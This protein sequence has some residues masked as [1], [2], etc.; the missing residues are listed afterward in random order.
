M[1]ALCLCMAFAIA[2]GSVCAGACGR[3]SL[4]SL[5]S[6]AFDIGEISRPSGAC[7]STESKEVGWEVTSNDPVGIASSSGLMGWVV[8]VVC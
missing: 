3:Y 6:L 2:S 4:A 8:Y 5:V 1:E 7:I